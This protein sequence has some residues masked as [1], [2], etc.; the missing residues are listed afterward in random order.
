MSRLVIS[1]DRFGLDE[2][3]LSVSLA[4]FDPESGALQEIVDLRARPEVD[5][6]PGS[7]QPRLAHG[8]APGSGAGP[9]GEKPVSRDAADYFQTGQRLGDVVPKA[10]GDHQIELA[11]GFPIEHVGEHEI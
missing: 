5:G 6:T 2:I 4:G 7:L 8:G 9:G 11:V 10:D 1:S 3:K